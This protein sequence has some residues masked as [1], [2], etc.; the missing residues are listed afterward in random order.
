MSFEGFPFNVG[1]ELTLAC[2]LRCNHCASAAGL[3][4]PDEL[5]T[6]EALKICDQ[7]PALL[8]QE[9]DL[10]GGE[11]LLRKDWV[12][13]ALYLQDLGIAT[14]ILTNGLA[15]GSETVSQ[16]KQVGIS[17]V[18]ISLDGLERTHDSIRSRN[19][20]FEHVINSIGLLQK[21]NIN[22]IVITTVNDL[23]I[24]E[25]SDILHLLQSLGVRHWR[26]Q[27]LIPIG[28][29]INFKELEMS[30][31]GILKL[32]NFIR[33]WT[34]KAAAKG[35]QI[36]CSDGLEYIEGTTM[37]DR[38][39]RGCPGGWVTCGITSD[40]KVKGCLSLPDEVVDG[41]LR[42]N[43]LWDIWFHPNSFVYSRYCSTEQLG[44][45]CISC[46]KATECKGGCSANS[47]AATGVYHNDPYCYYKLNNISNHY[48][49]S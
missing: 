8:V 20:S 12:E 22:I 4:R 17:N 37:P 26:L 31:Q 29:V 25:L 9:V 13:I 6:E 47:Y 36:I 18:G 27:P 41:D 46:D 39:W 42:K 30:S 34:P 2:N 44:Y 11:P 7:F 33:Y 23:N 21:E 49:N 16:M 19:G 28:R 32:G 45:N 38:P 40:G 24:D 48:E 5:T 3:P 1:W 14:N 43:D 15:V 35:M 10:T